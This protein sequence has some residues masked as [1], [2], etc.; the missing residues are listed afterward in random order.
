MPKDPRRLLCGV[1]A[2]T[3]NLTDIAFIRSMGLHC[4]ACKMGAATHLED[5]GEGA[6]DV[7]DVPNS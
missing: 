1:T 5:G 2:H 3:A 7:E 6:I 4:W